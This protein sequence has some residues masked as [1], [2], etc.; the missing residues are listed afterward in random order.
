MDTSTYIIAA[1]LL[2]LGW[3]W[4]CYKI[5]ERKG[6]INDVNL[7]LHY[8]RNETPR[9]P[10]TQQQLFVLRTLSHEVG[11]SPPSENITTTAATIRIE[12]LLAAKQK[13][14]DRGVLPPADP[15]GP[16]GPITDKQLKFIAKLSREVGDEFDEREVSR[17]TVA[18]AS[19]Y[20]DMLLEDRAQLRRQQRAARK[21]RRQWDAEGKLPRR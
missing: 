2:L 3:S 20:I 4:A 6:R 18:E 10:A 15:D 5:G 1:L 11:V 9:K 16:E 13:L 12:E 17:M 19:V 21:Q 14:R 8:L 7:I